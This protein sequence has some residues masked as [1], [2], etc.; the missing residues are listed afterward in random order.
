MA[1]G[2]AAAAASR[3]DYGFD[4]KNGQGKSWASLKIC[5]PLSSGSTKPKVPIIWGSELVSGSFDLDLDAPQ[6]FNSISIV[7]RGRIIT[8]SYEDGT[9][10]FLEHPVT[11]WNRSHGDPRS[12]S[13]SPTGSGASRTKKSD[14]KLTGK[15]SWPFSF[16]F[17]QEVAIR[18]R[19]QKVYPTPQS[20]L[21]RKTK[22]SVQYDLVVRM[23]HGM[24]RSDTKL[25]ANI[26]YIP[27]VAPGPSSMLRQVAYLECLRLPSPEVDPSGWFS[28]TPATI[29][30]MLFNERPVQLR[31]SVSL[32]DPVCYTRGTVI[33]CHMSVYS[34]DPV[35][36]DVLANP[37]S[38]LL[39]LICWITYYE[40][41][42]RS[43]TRGSSPSS[44]NDGG[45]AVLSGAVMDASIVGTAVW[46][47]NPDAGD[48]QEN[49]RCLD[50]EIHLEKDL[51]PS[52]DF[53]L[54]KV[55][56]T[57]ELYPFEAPSFQCSSRPKM[58]H[59]VTITTV[60]GEGPVP[61]AV[62]NHVPCKPRALKASDYP[63]MQINRSRHEYTTFHQQC[64]DSRI[65]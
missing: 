5:C 33:P 8:S 34:A 31:C 53:L 19:N 32:A 56:Y 13:A 64:F 65:R 17:P 23:T 25:N 39:C 54:F 14:G 58:S 30:G 24:L 12:S 7:L 22:V 62:T 28:I 21:D 3:S 46:W 18:Q 35:A 51:Q 16:P 1:D 49:I 6:N 47:V 43:L 40:D 42:E 11:S 38:A 61:I 26:Q 20:F 44:D 2:A 10:T 60:H 63:E 36:L 15:Y 55:S 4:V 57:V 41:P 50:G 9:Y 29:G 27:E 59:P 48:Q 37:E 45:N 52:C